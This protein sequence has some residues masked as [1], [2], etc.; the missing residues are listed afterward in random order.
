MSIGSTKN[1]R[2]YNAKRKV[3]ITKNGQDRWVIIAYNE[4][5]YNSTE[6]DLIDVIDWVK[7]N[8][9]EILK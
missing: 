6:V 4:G 3:A 5:G 8:I 9:P 7:G 2:E 1:I